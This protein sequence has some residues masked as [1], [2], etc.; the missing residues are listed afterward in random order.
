MAATA[1]G[2]SSPPTTCSTAPPTATAATAGGTTPPPRPGRRH[3][4][5]QVRACKWSLR[6]QQGAAMRC[7]SSYHRRGLASRINQV[8]HVWP[9]GPSKNQGKLPSRPSSA[10]LAGKC[11]PLHLLQ[12]VSRPPASGWPMVGPAA[13]PASKQLA[14]RPVSSQTDRPQVQHQV[15]AKVASAPQSACSAQTTWSQGASQVLSQARAAIAVQVHRSRSPMGQAKQAGSCPFAATRSV[16]LKATQA[17]QV[18]LQ[19][20]T[21]AVCWDQAPRQVRK[22]LRPRLP[23]PRQVVDTQPG[24]VCSQSLH[25]IRSPRRA[26]CKEPQIRTVQCNRLSRTRQ[27]RPSGHSRLLGEQGFKESQTWH[28]RLLLTCK[29]SP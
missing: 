21:C 11:L 1:G 16:G 15:Q 19:G 29:A 26:K 20:F 24:R 7:N 4:L 25:P 17:A 27:C 6:A 3:P 23:R 8:R 13:K 9:A 28:S 18:G 14:K 22:L 5:R 12:F 2:S 10:S